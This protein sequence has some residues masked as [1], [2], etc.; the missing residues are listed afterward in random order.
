M[1][2]GTPERQDLSK[3]RTDQG[4]ECGS[5]E[6]DQLC[7]LGHT[8][9]LSGLSPSA[10]VPKQRLKLLGRWDY[11][12]RKNKVGRRSMTHLSP[13]APEDCTVT[14]K[15]SNLSTDPASEFTVEANW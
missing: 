10:G 1:S 8:H 7:V 15:T 6:I 11:Y 5:G 9:F 13:P 12:F 2:W 14:R 3:V 4:N